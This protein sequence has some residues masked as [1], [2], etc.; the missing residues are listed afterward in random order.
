MF[1]LFRPSRK[2]DVRCRLLPPFVA[3]RRQ[4]GSLIWPFSLTFGATPPVGCLER[5]TI[6]RLTL[7]PVVAAAAVLISGDTAPAPELIENARGCDMLVHEA[8]FDGE[9]QAATRAA[10]LTATAHRE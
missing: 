4:S 10:P 2:T 9:L 3:P 7:V 8:L 6:G 5:T 1:A